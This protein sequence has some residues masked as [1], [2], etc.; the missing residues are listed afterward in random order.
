MV[1]YNDDT[2]CVSIIICSSV[3]N[4]EL[5]EYYYYYYEATPISVETASEDR[6]VVLF[7][8]IPVTTVPIP[9]NLLL[10][11]WHLVVTHRGSA[12]YIVLNATREWMACCNNWTV[13]SFIHSWDRGKVERCN[14]CRE[15]R[16]GT[17][18]S[19]WHFQFGPF[20]SNCYTLVLSTTVQD[21][22]LATVT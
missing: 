20:I 3:G 8:S 17:K 9:V 1:I 21:N 16:G 15:T 14:T 10:I 4:P 12:T 19:P 18:L 13:D 6:N 11:S 22:N 2:R 5:W 7:K